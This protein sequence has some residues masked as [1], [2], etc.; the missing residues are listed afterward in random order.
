AWCDRKGLDTV[1]HPITKCVIFLEDLLSDMVAKNSKDPFGTVR[2]ARK[3]LSKIRELQRGVPP[4]YGEAFS[5]ETLIRSASSKALA[6]TTE[7]RIGPDS[8]PL[9]DG[10]QATSLDQD[11]VERI[12]DACIKHNDHWSGFRVAAMVLLGTAMGFRGDD[13]MDAKPSLLALTPV[14]RS[15][16]VPMQPVTCSLRTGKVNSFG[17][18]RYSGFVRHKEPHLDAAGALADLLVFTL[19]LTGLDILQKIE[20]QDTTWWQYRLLFRDLYHA[21]KKQD[22]NA[23]AKPLQNILQ[24]VDGSPVVKTK[25]LHLFRDSGVI[26]LASGGAGSE[27]LSIWGH[28]ARG[29]LQQAYLEKN[30]LSALVAFAIAGGW[31]QTSFM[32]R[33]FCG[34]AL[35]MVPERWIDSLFPGVRKVLDAVRARNARLQ[36]GK[37]QADD[38]V[39][40]RAAEGFLQTVLYSGICFWQNLPFRTQRYGLA[41][42]LH[43]L[44]AVAAIIAT[45]EYHD[46]AREVIASHDKANKQAELDVSASMGEMLT[47]MQAC[48]KQLCGASAVGDAET[49]AK[50]IAEKMKSMNSCS[51]QGSPH[52]TFEEDLTLPL[53]ASASALTH[54]PQHAI[55][56]PDTPREAKR[57]KATP[58]HGRYLLWEATIADRVSLIKA[59]KSL[60]VGARNSS[61]HKKNRHLP[62]LIEMLVN[63]GATLLES[64]RLMTQ[65]ADHFDLTLDQMREGARLLNGKAAKPDCTALT[66]ETN[67]TVGHFR[68]GI[69]WAQGEIR[70]NQQE[71]SVVAN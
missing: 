37:R 10:F 60:A 8:D 65:I 2:V 47:D 56:L 35:V 51:A 17:W 30:P 36:S 26:L 43:R 38:R 45:Q 11:E 59:D 48:L 42:A 33:H 18:L 34:R 5:K 67:V 12:L 27:L 46:F 55:T 64:I 58:I 52:D 68:Q 50:L 15:T 20:S 40:D 44:P 66:A 31:D 25:V 61:L 41:Y 32:G 13:L 4:P 53:S 49:V 6:A 69:A 1:I 9:R 28:W 7:A 62:Q 22:R 63:L 57:L 19:N 16:P 24:E 21:D 29:T 3:A 23:L 71:Q 39:S 54:S 70:K 14:V